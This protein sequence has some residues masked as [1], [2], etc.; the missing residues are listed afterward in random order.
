M[1]FT[2][3]KLD[4]ILS[5]YLPDQKF[6]IAYS[7]GLDSHVLLHAMCSLARMRNWQLQAIHVNHGLQVAAPGWAQH[8]QDVCRDLNIHSH[9]VEVDA[10]AEPGESPEARARMARY[11]VMADYAQSGWIIVTAHHQ[12]DQAETF[13]LQLLRGSGLKGLAAMP[14][15]QQLAG[16][17]LLRPLLDFR[18]AD[19]HQYARDHQLDWIEDG[20]NADVSIDRNY[21]RHVLW[22]HLSARWPAAGRTI[23]R[24]A[25]HAAE[26]AALAED[27]ARQDR[28][29]A[30]KA[31]E[32]ALQLWVLRSLSLARRRNLLRVWI[33]DHD[34]SVPSTD[35]LEQI[36]TNLIDAGSDREPVVYWHGHE[37]RRYRE[38]LYLLPRL[39]QIAPETCLSWDMQSSLALPLGELRACRHHGPGLKTEVSARDDIEI[40]FRRGGEVIRLP[41]RRHHH[42]LKNLLQTSGL[43]SWLRDF[44]PLVYINNELALVPGICA[45]ANWMAEPQEAAIKVLWTLPTPLQ[46]AV[47]S[48]RPVNQESMR[49]VD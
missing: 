28:T 40:R 30:T 39:P 3:Q 22:P 9:I 4:A 48:V 41:G 21:L 20:S 16:G 5:E 46:E 35:V 38:R 6:A 49:D 2:I 1:A 17:W 15:L 8:C 11:A 42:T 14:R 44:L 29:A 18:R 13:L 47:A 37:F 34:L 36:V 7:G 25:E 27:M 12:E 43:P 23:A 45:G 33:R 24:A 26:T 19:L 32:T 31:G 10:R